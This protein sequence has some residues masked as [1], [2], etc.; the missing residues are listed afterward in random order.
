MDALTPPKQL[1]LHKLDASLAGVNP[2]ELAEFLIRRKSFL[3][4]D[5]RQLLQTHFSESSHGI[6]GKED[7][8]LHQ[9]IID[10][11]KA[12]K[13]LRL[14]A[15]PENMD[16]KDK[17]NIR[18]AKEALSSSTTLLKTLTMTLEKIYNIDRV[19]H[20]QQTLVETLHKECEPK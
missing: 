7:F 4:N 2:R 13:R 5:V 16:P 10:Q 17:L 12:A 19:R 8:D 9:E 11:M 3:P 6:D 18:D 14:K 15:L 20:L 1:A